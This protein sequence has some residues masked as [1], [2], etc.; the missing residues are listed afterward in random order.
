MPGTPLPIGYKAPYNPR[1]HLVRLGS[2]GGRADP[3][4]NPGT[5]VWNVWVSPNARPNLPGDK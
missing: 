5:I 3:E 4:T 1:P 2:V